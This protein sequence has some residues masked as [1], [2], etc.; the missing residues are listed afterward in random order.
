[1]QVLKYMTAEEGVAMM[2][3]LFNPLRGRHV[4]YIG[5]NGRKQVREVVEEKQ[6]KVEEESDWGVARQMDLFTQG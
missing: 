5:S 4:G 2:K 3:Q 1:M 6:A